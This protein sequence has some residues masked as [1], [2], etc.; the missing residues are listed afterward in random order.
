[1]MKLILSDL[2]KGMILLDHTLINP[3]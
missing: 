2:I 1:M 3:L